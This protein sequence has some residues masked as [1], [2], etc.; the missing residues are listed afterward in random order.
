MGWGY[1]GMGWGMGLVMLLAVVGFWLVVVL[2]VRAL[3]S[4]RPPQ[5]RPLD[6][7]ATLEHRYARGEIDRDE[8]IRM[9]RDL[10]GDQSAK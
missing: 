4:A 10:L 5:R 7:L 1:A 3:F 9:R 6:A 2:V 8:F